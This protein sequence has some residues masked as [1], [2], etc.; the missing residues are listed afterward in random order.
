MNNK[1]VSK[2]L[3]YKK[4]CVLTH[5]LEDVIS[6]SFLN[7]SKKIYDIPNSNNNFSLEIIEKNSKYIFG[8]YGKLKSSISQNVTVLVDDKEYVEFELKY[9]VYFLIDIN[10]QTL[11][12][13]NNHNVKQFIEDLQILLEQAS[14]LVLSIKIIDIETDDVRQKIK[15]SKKISSIIITESDDIQRISKEFNHEYVK[16]VETIVKFNSKS[17]HIDKNNIIVYL[18]KNNKNKLKFTDEDEIDRVVQINALAFSKSKRIKLSIDF[19]S[20]EKYKCLMDLLIEQS[21]Y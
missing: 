2:V 3:I 1:T 19:L 21:R 4:I 5:T 15:K 6:K 14:N 18:E 12:Y 11:L 17:K 13:I 16:S 20:K 8:K 7:N 10:N 9:L